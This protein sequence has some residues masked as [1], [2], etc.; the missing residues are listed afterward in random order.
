MTRKTRTEVDV[1]FWDKLLIAPQ[2][3]HYTVLISAFLLLELNL[4][5]NTK[6]K[7]YYE[8]TIKEDIRKKK[9]QFII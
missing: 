7:I 5:S 4:V 6:V 1:S 3:S 9:K 2:Q 8:L